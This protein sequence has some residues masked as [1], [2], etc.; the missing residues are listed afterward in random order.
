MALHCGIDLHANN[1]VVA[2]VDD[3]DKARFEKRL[4]N[5]VNRGR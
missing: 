4:P 5:E 2:V 3:Q 1:S